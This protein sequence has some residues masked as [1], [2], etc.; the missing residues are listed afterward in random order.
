MAELEENINRINQKFQQL[1]KQYRHLQKENEQLQ[2]SLDKMKED[3]SNEIS[4]TEQLKQQVAI[5]KT[6]VGTMNE[7]DKKIFEK[8]IN[9]Y[10]KEIDKCIALISE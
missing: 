1:M 5:L 3:F 8:N 7:S 9:T 10:I 6:S 4:R 2:I